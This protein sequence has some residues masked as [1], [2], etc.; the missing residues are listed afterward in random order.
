MPDALLYLLAGY[1][2]GAAHVWWATRG[3]CD[4]ARMQGYREGQRVSGQR[5]ERD[6]G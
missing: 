3:D 6:N 4:R 5:K 1:L 2:A